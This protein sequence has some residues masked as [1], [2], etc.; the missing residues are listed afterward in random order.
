MKEMAPLYSKSRLIRAARDGHA[1]NPDESL[2]MQQVKSVSSVFIDVDMVR[3][4][5]GDEIA[6][7][8][9]WMNFLQK[10]L[11]LP[12]FCSIVVF[13][14]N[15]T[16]FDLTTSPLAGLFSILMSVWGTIYLVSWRRHC[17]SLDVLW[18]DA[19]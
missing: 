1:E 5:Y 12:A 15:A 17:R 7:Y 8:F 4:Y 10:W 11:L 19:N 9:E 2:L 13:I 18:D 14:G 6:I 16:V 3:D